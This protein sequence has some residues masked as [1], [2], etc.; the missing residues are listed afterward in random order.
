MLKSRVVSREVKSPHVPMSSVFLRRRAFYV[1]QYHSLRKCSRFQGMSCFEHM[2][3]GNPGGGVTPPVTLLVQVPVLCIVGKQKRQVQYCMVDTVQYSTGQHTNFSL[4]SQR[5]YRAPA[6][7]WVLS[8]S[9]CGENIQAYYCVP[10]TRYK[11]SVVCDV[12]SLVPYCT[13]NC[14]STGTLYPLVLQYQQQDE[15]FCKK[16]RT[17]QAIFWVQKYYS[18]C[19]QYCIQNY[20]YLIFIRERY[21]FKILTRLFR[22]AGISYFVQLLQYSTSRAGYSTVLSLQSQLVEYSTWQVLSSSTRTHTTNLLHVAR[23]GNHLLSTCTN[24]RQ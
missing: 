1:D 14:T 23:D 21:F 17:V 8:S 24:R 19:V 10:G 9:T 13:C 12:S 18:T 5:S 6:Q 3:Y 15:C 11:Y 4:S 22:V 7:I 16:Y 2:P 20:T